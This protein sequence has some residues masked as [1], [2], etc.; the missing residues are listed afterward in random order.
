MPNPNDPTIQDIEDFYN[1][2]KEWHRVVSKKINQAIDNEGPIT[3]KNPTG[4]GIL[5]ISDP[6]HLKYLRLG[7]M[8]A[9]VVIKTFPSYS[10]LEVKTNETT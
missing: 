9:N 7:L 4:E 8:I 6:E 2:T 5:V 3:L 1:L 10:Y